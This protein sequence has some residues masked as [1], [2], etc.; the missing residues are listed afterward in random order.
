MNRGIFS[1]SRRLAFVVLVSLLT[2]GGTLAVASPAGADGGHG[3]GP[4]L[5][6][7]TIEPETANFGTLFTG[8]T[9]DPIVFTVSNIGPGT[10]N[11]L[12]TS[13]EVLL[14]NDQ[15]SIVQ[16]SCAGAQLGPFTSCSVSVVYHPHGQFPLAI[17]ALDVS[18]GPNHCC[19][20]GA[21]A[22]F[23]GRQKFFTVGGPPPAVVT[24]GNPP[25]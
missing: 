12:I 25:S 3:R 14:G 17:G 1:R 2:I 22:F 11:P 6:K 21:E 10:T 20:P 9:S 16:D 19:P 7:F 15:F 4:H 24:N 18:N 8:Q 23:S 13:I 5:P